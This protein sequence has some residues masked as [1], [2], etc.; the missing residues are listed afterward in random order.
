MRKLA[1][2]GLVFAQPLA[3]FAF[4]NTIMEHDSLERSLVS[5]RLEGE[6]GTWPGHEDADEAAE[7]EAADAEKEAEEAAREDA[8]AAKKEAKDGLTAK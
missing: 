5:H 2:V 6:K 3:M 8:E 1:I 4:V 7:K